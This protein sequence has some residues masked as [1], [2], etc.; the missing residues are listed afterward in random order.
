MEVNSERL[1]AKTLMKLKTKNLVLLKM[2]SRKL[3]PLKSKLKK[4]W[5]IHQKGH[6]KEILLKIL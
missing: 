2:E 4:N 5:A 6:F 1:W 3:W